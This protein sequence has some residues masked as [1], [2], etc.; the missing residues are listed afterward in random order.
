VY[1]TVPFDGTKKNVFNYYIQPQLSKINGLC[2]IDD[3]T[4]NWTV[5]FQG[6]NYPNLKFEIIDE[7]IPGDD[8]YYEPVC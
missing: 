8:K 3:I 5:V 6:T 2:S 4:G 1:Q 7:I